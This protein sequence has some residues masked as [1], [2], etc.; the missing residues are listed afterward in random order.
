M[1]LAFANLGVCESVV[2]RV[3]RRHRRLPLE[4]KIEWASRLKTKPEIFD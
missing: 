2:S 4:K 1:I 3:I